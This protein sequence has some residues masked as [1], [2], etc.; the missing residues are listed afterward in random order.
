MCVCARVC[1][2][3]KLLGLADGAVSLMTPKGNLNAAEEGE[4]AKQMTNKTWKVT[5]KKIP[6]ERERGRRG[7]EKIQILSLRLSYSLS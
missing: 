5:A 2:R 3:V 1:A 4:N 7:E 6:R